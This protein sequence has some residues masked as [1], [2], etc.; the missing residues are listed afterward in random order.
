[1]CEY[2]HSFVSINYYNVNPR[3]DSDAD[4][5]INDEN[6]E[7]NDESN[8]KNND[9]TLDDEDGG[10]IIN[11]GPIKYDQ[12]RIPITVVHFSMSGRHAV[13]GFYRQIV[14][15]FKQAGISW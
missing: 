11:D 8:V 5:A 3:I 12:S 9:A 1:M 7:D 6:E 14:S 10:I 4:E 13:F 2:N 15:P